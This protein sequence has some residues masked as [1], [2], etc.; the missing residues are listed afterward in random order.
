MDD[1]LQIF[2]WD[3]TPVGGKTQVS[4][5]IMS[6]PALVSYTVKNSQMKTSD[7]GQKYE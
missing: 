1:K 3:F 4:W 5:L 2:L 6:K 7:M